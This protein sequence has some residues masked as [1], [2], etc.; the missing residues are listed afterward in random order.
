MT[1]TLTR[2]ATG[3]APQPKRRRTVSGKPFA[4]GPMTYVIASVIAQ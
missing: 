2:R 1:A 4:A 3:R